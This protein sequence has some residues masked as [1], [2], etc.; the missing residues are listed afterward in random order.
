MFDKAHWQDL[1]AVSDYSDREE[2]QSAIKIYE[3][4]LLN[5]SPGAL[6]CN[7]WLRFRACYGD[8]KSYNK[9]KL[10]RDLKCSIGVVNKY[11]DELAE[12]GELRHYHGTWLEPAHGHL[13]FIQSIQGGPIK[14]GRTLDIDKRI[15]Q[16]QTSSPE[17]LVLVGFILN[18]GHKESELHYKFRQFRLH[19]EWF[20]PVAELIEY[21][22]E[23][24]TRAGS[25]KIFATSI[26]E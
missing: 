10:A 17:Q 4:D 12:L 14:I 23:N 22:K 8:I 2:P 25:G 9:S 3:D 15:G 7:L 21:I 20:E 1:W 26:N 24:A 13:Y 19:G 6:K 18:E 16:L 5:I 11:L